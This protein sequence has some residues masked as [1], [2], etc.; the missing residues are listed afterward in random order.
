MFNPDHFDS[1]WYIGS[2]RVVA[3]LMSGHNRN[4]RT[5]ILNNHN[6]EKPNA[7]HLNFDILVHD[8]QARCQ[9]ELDG[10]K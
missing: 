7:N 4:E 2:P 3:W 6:R 10:W 1:K 9:R 8:G 5:H